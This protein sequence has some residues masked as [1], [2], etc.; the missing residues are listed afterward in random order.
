MVAALA[1]G[2]CTAEDSTAAPDTPGSSEVSAPSAGAGAPRRITAVYSGRICR[3]VKEVKP[4]MAERK[5][6]FDGALRSV[7]VPHRQAMVRSEVQSARSPGR[8]RRAGGACAAPV[9]ASPGTVRSGA[10]LSARSPALSP[11]RSR[12][13]SPNREQTGATKSPPRPPRKDQELLAQK[14]LLE[15][16][17][18]EAQRSKVT[19]QRML[20]EERTRGAADRAKLAALGARIEQLE[21]GQQPPRLFEE[22]QT[23]HTAL[24]AQSQQIEI[25]R[26]QVQLLRDGHVAEPEPQLR[27]ENLRLRRDLEQSRAMLSRYTEELAAIMPGMQ[28]VLQKFNQDVQPC[29]S[30]DVKELK[31]ASRESSK[32]VPNAPKAV[33]DAPKAVTKEVDIQDVKEAPKK[34]LD[35]KDVTRD[36]PKDTDARNVAGSPEEPRA[37]EA[38]PASPSRSARLPVAAVIEEPPVRRVSSATTARADVRPMATSPGRKKA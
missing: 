8:E 33:K 38:C 27:E 34:V 23:L 13:S 1:E 21:R 18:E 29:R 16:Q 24:E 26:Q 9:R 15:Q 12:G 35:M 20:N 5:E 6:D 4:P 36:M 2:A 37:L 32:E 7:P 14:A 11:G 22:N 3:P 30:D 28:K 25:L 19:L 17:I 31:D 10:S